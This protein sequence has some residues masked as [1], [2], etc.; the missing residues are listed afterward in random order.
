MTGADARY[1]DLDAARS[2]LPS[3]LRRADHPALALT[4]SAMAITCGF[5]RL[6]SP[7]EHARRHPSASHHLRRPA[8]GRE[9]RARWP[10]PRRPHHQ[11]ETD[12]AALGA[13]VRRADELV[14]APRHGAAVPGRAAHD[15]VLPRGLQ[16]D[17]LPDLLHLLPS[18]AGAIRGGPRP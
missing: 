16:R 2:V 9:D 17:R 7:H 15:A 1:A 10:Y 4:E 6:R 11:H 12:A 18:A 8:A 14:P 5:S 13:G 3:E